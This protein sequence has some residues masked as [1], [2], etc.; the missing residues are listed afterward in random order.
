MREIVTSKVH[1]KR[2]SIFDNSITYK[3]IHQ[4]LVDPFLVEID[5]FSLVSRA[6]EWIW[7]WT[8]EDKCG[9]LGIEC[10][11]MGQELG[12]FV[13]ACGLGVEKTYKIWIE[14]KKI[15]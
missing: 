6:L 2:K 11:V 15:F 13:L 5:T 10:N 8:K 9:E 1:I 12:Q 7:I 4:G 14:N 3:L